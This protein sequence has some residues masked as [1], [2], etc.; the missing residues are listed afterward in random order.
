MYASVSA[1]ALLGF[2]ML[3]GGT[4]RRVPAWKQSCLL[5]P[6]ALLLQPLLLLLLPLPLPLPLLRLR[7]CPCF[8]CCC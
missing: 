2:C 1:L 3:L 5:L 4:L 8:R 7:C 6:L